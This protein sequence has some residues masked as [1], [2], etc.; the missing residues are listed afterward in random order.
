MRKAKLFALAC[1]ICFSVFSVPSGVFADSS[2]Q[3][4][5]TTED[6]QAMEIL[7]DANTA[8]TDEN[9]L[10][11]GFGYITANNSSRLLLD[12]KS[13]NPDAYWNLLNQLFNPDGAIA[14]THIKIEMGADINSSSGT[15]PATKRSEEE[16]ADVTRGAGFQLAADALSINP[17][18]TLELLSWGAPGYT[19]DGEN[20]DEK[21]RLRYEWFKE[22]LDAAYKTYGLEFSYIAPNYNEKA[23]DANWIKYFA[24]ALKSET[25]TPYPYDEIK[26]VA[27][28]EECGYTLA[29]KMLS[30]EE[31]MDAVDVIGIHYTSTSDENTLKCKEEYGKE[32]WY[33]EGLSPAEVSD[34]AANADGSGIS[35][36]NSLLD[37]AGRIVNM[38]PNGG[39][40]RYEFQPAVAAYYSGATYYPKQL[41]TANEPWSGYTEIGAG[42]Y[43][44]EHFSLFSEQ[45]W[46][47]VKSACYGDGTEE[48]HVLSD[49]T[50]NYMTLCDPDTGDYSTILVNNTENT[51]VY[52]FTVKNLDKASSSV[53]VWETRG[54]DD[55][56][57]YDANYF[58]NVMQI[59][60][61]ENENGEY[62]Y[63][64]TVKP[65]S[66]V[67]VSTLEVTAIDFSQ[68]AENTRLELPYTDDFEYEDYSE[69]YL[70]S[71]GYAPRYTTDQS[72]AFEVVEDEERGNVLRQQI[73]TDMKGVEWALSPNPVT[74]L[75]DDTWA[76]YTVS[77]DVKLD[78]VTYDDNEP[79][80]T[81]VGIGLRYINSSASQSLSGYR[82]QITG[83]GKWQVKRLNE[84][85]GEG[86]IEGFDITEW[87]TLSITAAGD[88]LSAT[89]NG[90]QVF[91]QTLS[92]EV[93]FSGRV[94]LFSSYSLNCF[95][96][97]S[98]VAA[99][100]TNYIVRVDNLDSS[101]TLN[102]D[103]E[104]NTMDSYTCHNRTSSTV[105]DGGSITFSF[106]G[107]SFA[108]IGTANNAQIKVTIDGTEGDAEEAS[109]STAK[110]AFW[111][112]YSLGY[113][114]HEVKIEILSGS[115]TLDA[116]E[117]GSMTVLK[118]GDLDGGL[119]EDDKIVGNPTETEKRSNVG[120]AIAT[121]IVAAAAVGIIALAVHAKRK[122]K[123][124]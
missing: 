84:T 35:G 109:G 63:Q 37:V 102:G 26:I 83:D 89:V 67:T 112:R 18:I 70:E 3:S 104:H 54:P 116:I 55:G 118:D 91:S 105:T 40:T 98:V 53:Q 95:D 122:R 64:L 11:Q 42:V 50:N 20:A 75:G 82:I 90:Q 23:V 93:T 114:K 34:L 5:V 8:S 77:A 1:A 39:F 60:P 103:W 4:T 13:E 48:N 49:T 56:E 24:N 27:A 2:S 45:G 108:L 6:L 81:Y 59:E 66:M 15:E 29:E 31:L 74:T 79:A 17:N 87:Y 68:E 106:E 76:N 69:D 46:Q 57:E 94:A 62:T 88:N 115:V 41:I 21:H 96:N 73:T 61:T 47:F 123:K 7:I 113:D 117:Y 22:T 72:G 36:V 19:A 100:M 10:W 25:D 38:Y 99:E 58:K 65:Y 52:Q 85:L 78:E 80:D 97:L 110:S 33:S 9:D 124:S 101:I 12:Y 107:D 111:H 16:E 32:I 44:C 71:R 14:M 43:M 51:R 120:I 119:I 30:D 86:D 121:G 28:D 92:G